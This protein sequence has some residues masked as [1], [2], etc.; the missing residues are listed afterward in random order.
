MIG[1]VDPAGVIIEIVIIVKS[2]KSD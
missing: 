1:F 2:R